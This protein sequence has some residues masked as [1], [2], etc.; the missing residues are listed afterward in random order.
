LIFSRSK[1]AV[2]VDL[3][4]YRAAG[5]DG[6]YLLLASPGLEAAKGTVQKKDVCFVLDTSGSMSGAKIEQ[7]KKALSFCLNNLDETDH[8]E[9]IRFSTE[10]EPLFNELRPASKENVTKALD[11]VK[12]LKAVGGTAIQD[13]VH[14]ALGYK[15]INTEYEVVFLTDGEPTVG[16]TNEDTLVNQFT[17]ESGGNTR[18]FCFGIGNDVNTHLL[19]RIATETR[20]SSTYVAPEEDIEIKVSNFYTKIKEPVLSNVNLAFTGDNI[21]VSQ[22]YPGVMPDLFKGEMLIAFGRYS[23][24]GASA[25]KITGTLNG[26]QQTF[27]TDVH[28]ADVDTTNAYIP[29]LWATRR[30]GYLLDQIRMHGESKELKDEVTRLAREHGIVT[31]YTAYLILE[32]EKSRNVPLALQ[33]LREFGQDNRAMEVNKAKSKQVAQEAADASA[34]TGDRAV[35]AAKDVDALKNNA[36]FDRQNNNL[37]LDDLRKLTPAAPQQDP[38]AFTG[39][40]GFAGPTTQPTFGYREAQNYADQAR[41]VNGRAFYQNGSQWTDSTAQNRKDLKK[42]EIAFNSDEYFDLLKRHPEAA[43][44]FSLGT[45]LD[46]VLDDTLYVV[47]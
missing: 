29:R 18:I 34:R 2:G 36:N 23:G 1:Q 35:Q 6:Y 15:R 22:M 12:G 14:Q 8:F 4:T 42:K 25:V 40:R 27:V 5:E 46:V 32:D 17:K 26:E 7:A 37:A 16:E 47:R 41:V 21:R 13:A 38:R 43:A 33:S 30:V 28:F 11:F 39:G 3:L 9:V 20:A 19:D 44:W 45:E 31:P 24:K 10:S